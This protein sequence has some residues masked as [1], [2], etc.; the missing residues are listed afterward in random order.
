M[1]NKVTATIV[2]LAVVLMFVAANE[3][4]PTV[5]YCVQDQQQEDHLHQLMTEALDE[6]FKEHINH[7]FDIWIKDQAESPAR[8]INGASVGINAYVRANRNL[9]SWKPPRC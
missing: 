7:L 6:A 9:H 8:A 3:P 5:K 2:L 4:A 1:L